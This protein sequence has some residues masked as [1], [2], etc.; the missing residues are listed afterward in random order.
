MNQRRA[1]TPGPW[2]KTAAWRGASFMLGFAVLLLVVDWLFGGWLEIGFSRLQLALVV[3]GLALSAPYG[4]A[5]L[6]GELPVRKSKDAPPVVLPD[7][8]EG[9]HGHTYVIVNSAPAASSGGGGMKRQ[10]RAKELGPGWYALYTVFWRWPVLAGD[11]ILS[12]VWSLLGRVFGRSNGQR[13]SDLEQVDGS[14][15]H[16]SPERSRF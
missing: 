9:E 8:I 11:T 6:H 3:G 2:N 13:S 16:P 5:W 12:G 10:V 1:L 15:R 14:D 4:L 7:P